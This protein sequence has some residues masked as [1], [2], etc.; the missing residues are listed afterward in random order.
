MSG[1]EPHLILLSRLG[2]SFGVSW[3]SRRALGKQFS[4]GQD[5]VRSNN[6]VRTNGYCALGT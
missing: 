6:T 3:S 2:A 1:S 5:V 4:G